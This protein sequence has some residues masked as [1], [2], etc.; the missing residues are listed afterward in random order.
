MLGGGHEPAHRASAAPQRSSPDSYAARTLT[1]PSGKARVTSVS[2]TDRLHNRLTGV[3]LGS[4]HTGIILANQTD[5]HVCNWLPFARVLTAHGYRVLLWEYNVYPQAGD[6]LAA[7]GRR[8]RALGVRTVALVGASFGGTAS[9]VAARAMVPK[10]GVVVS[11]S[12]PAE[13]FG[14]SALSAVRAVRIP[15]LFI[16]SAADL[17]FSRDAR[18]MYAAAVSRDKKLV[19]LPGS[20]HGIDILDGPGGGHVRGLILAFLQHHIR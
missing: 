7:A 16:D 5:T 9:L 6:D 17:P 1:C 2:F 14:L 8:L 10:P 11:I 18:R 13:F 4:G 12:A 20:G 3:V 15:L 19:I